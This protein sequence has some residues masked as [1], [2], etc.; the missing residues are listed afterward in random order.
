MYTCYTAHS[1]DRLY[2]L[3]LPSYLPFRHLTAILSVRM[4]HLCCTAPQIQSLTGAAG[5]WNATNMQK[6]PPNTISAWLSCRIGRSQLHVSV[7]RRAVETLMGQGPRHLSRPTSYL[8][9]LVLSVSYKGES[10]RHGGLYVVM[11]WNGSSADP[12]RLSSSSN[13]TQGDCRK[14]TRA[15]KTTSN[16][17]RPFPLAGER[18]ALRHP[19]PC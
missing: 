19:T 1:Q 2:S 12:R 14:D 15:V 11:L 5:P 16:L 6:P 10:G 18:V 9:A 3:H 17:S 13:L 4:P 8:Q 7:V